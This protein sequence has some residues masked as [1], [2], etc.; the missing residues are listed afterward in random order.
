MFGQDDKREEQRSLIKYAKPVIVSTMGKRG[1]DKA[2]NKDS[3][4]ENIEDVLNSILPPREYTKDKQQLYIESVLSTPATETDVIILSHELD[5]RLQQ[6]KARE[7]GICAIREELYSQCFDELIRQI[8][9]ASVDRGI[10][11]VKIRDEM[12][13]LIQ[14]YQSLYESA[15]SYGMRKALQGEQYKAEMAKT[16]AALTAEVEKLNSEVKD[17][18]GQIEHLEENDRKEQIDSKRDHEDEVKKFKER[19]TGLRKTLEEK[20]SGEEKR[21]KQE[22]ERKERERKEKQE[23]KEKEKNSKRTAATGAAEPGK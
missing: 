20:L 15:L 8:T 16:K 23:R 2:E 10:E 9:I 22:K 13:M 5:K 4:A 18:Q 19:I 1:K 6:R 21:K 11:I 7:T 12:R 3:A 17:L 14:A